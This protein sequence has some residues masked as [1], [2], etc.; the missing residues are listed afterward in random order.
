MAPRNK[1]DEEQEKAPTAIIPTKAYEGLDAA[2]LE[3]VEI[4]ETLIP[5]FGILQK[6][7]PQVDK[8][9]DSYIP[10][11]EAGQIFNTSTMERYDGKK[12]I[13]FIPIHRDHKF[14]EWIPRDAGGGFVASYE[15]DSQTV[16]KAKKEA[17]AEGVF[18]KLTVG[19][20]D[21]VETFYLMGLVVEDDGSTTPGVVPFSST[22]IK[23]Y[24]QLITMAKSR[25]GR[26]ENGERF[27][28]PLFSHIYR[29]TTG[30]QENKKGKWHGWMISFDGGS[31]AT[32]LI[33]EDSELFQEAKRLREQVVAGLVAPDIKT[34][35]TSM[36]S[37]EDLGG[38]DKF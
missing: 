32:A 3:D 26:R 1:Q 12:G 16:L 31:A 7:S 29:L 11:A 22:Q 21:L 4:G 14:V 36:A 19:D 28:L 23:H 5:L 37:G 2:G 27:Q 30:L 34:Q 25:K 6:L 24:K 15:P 13:R 38:S 18:G 33:P 10:G 8:D 9:Q 17:G 20:N 35:D